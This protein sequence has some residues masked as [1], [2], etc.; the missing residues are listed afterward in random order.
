MIVSGNGDGTIDFWNAATHEKLGTT[1][2]HSNVVRD[3]AFSPDGKLL[4]TAGLRENAVKVWD[5]AS[6]EQKHTMYGH[7]DSVLSVA[8]SPDG[9]TLA[10]A[11]DDTSVRLWS[12]DT[13]E[14]LHSFYTPYG[15]MAVAF[16]SDGKRVAAGGSFC[17]VHV[18]DLATR[19]VL[20]EFQAHWDSIR[21][22][23]FAADEKTLV[24][25]GKDN[26][27]RMWSLDDAPGPFNAEPTG[28]EPRASFVVHP[29][30]WSFWA[31]FSPDGNMLAGG[32]LSVYCRVWN[33]KDFTSLA[34]LEVRKKEDGEPHGIMWQNSASFMPDGRSFVTCVTV[35]ERA[36]ELK[37][38]ETETFK[39]RARLEPS[40][41]PAKATGG[42][43]TIAVG[44]EGKKLFVASPA[45][46]LVSAIDMAT[47]ATLWSFPSLL[48]G[49][50]R[51]TA[52]S[53]N[54][55]ILAVG[56][57]LGHV[58][59]LDANT[60]KEIHEPLEHGSEWVTALAF[61]P[62]GTSLVSAG[63][64]GVIK[65]WELPSF[66]PETLPV[67]HADHIMSAAFSPDGTLLATIGTVWIGE[68]TPWEHQGEICLWDVATKKL[69]IKFHAHYG[70]VTSAV[71]S[72]DGKSLATTGRDG[73]INLWD[74]EELLKHAHH[75]GSPEQA[76]SVSGDGRE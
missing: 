30:S 76:G 22:L 70:S 56:T 14:L 1:H 42:G 13:G 60:G 47:G 26:S 45:Q 23:T 19:E 62:Q 72:P 57:Q 46:S 39:R 49:S 24:S 7:T 69:L 31:A 65:L 8:F 10:S 33:L 52:F 21:C 5:V 37:I 11:S 64:D 28:P 18:W 29:P 51:A 27:V 25:G 3:I 43:A 73:K 38:W 59:L 12:V 36:P 20:H 58:V 53:P 15:L 9:R 61:A 44:P 41:N 71:F 2:A 34:S 4:A 16:S 48:H 75:A 54:G 40:S 17:T 74:V 66:K 68:K 6:R 67:V 32:A 35:R 50:P 63:P 55:Q